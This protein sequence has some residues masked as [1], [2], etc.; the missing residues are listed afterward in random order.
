MKPPPFQT[1]RS[2]EVAGNTMSAMRIGFDT[3]QFIEVAGLP[4]EEVLETVAKDGYQGVDISATRQSAVD[5]SLFPQDD[6]RRYRDSAARLGL[7][8]VSVVTHLPMVNSVWQGAPIN[9]PGAI[10]LA[11]DVGARMV[12]VN[13]GSYQETTHSFDLAW[14]SAVEHLTDVC[15]Y[16]SGRNILVSLDG[17]SPGTLLSSPEKV[18]ALLRQVDSPCL[19]HTFDPCDLAIAGFDPAEAAKDLAEYIGHVHVK[20]YRGIYPEFQ[21]HI[22]GDG[23]LEYKTWIAAVRKLKY[24]GYLT[25]ECFESHTLKRASRLAHRTLTRFL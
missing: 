21:Y 9:I 25:V 19:R 18:L 11:V 23:K 12:N 8:V 10:D 5:P 7:E 17:L 15:R 24:R 22:P 13:V 3:S 4:I 16:A 6:R 1:P 2:T 14:E 20:D